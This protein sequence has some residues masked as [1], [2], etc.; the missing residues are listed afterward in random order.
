VSAGLLGVVLLGAC[1]STPQSTPVRTALHDRAITVAS[2]D[3]P[4][5]ELL[6]DIYGLALRD[7]GYAVMFG[8]RLGP[9]ELLDPALAR[10][11]VELVPEYAGTALQF[12]S[13][14]KAQ[15]SADVAATHQAL[16]RTLRGSELV[17]L[18][19]APA[20]DSNAIVVTPRTASEYGLRTISD[21]AKVKALL[22]FGGPPECPNRPLCLQ[23][24]RRTYGL[25]VKS[26]L[27]LDVGGPLTRQAL[28]QSQVDVALMFSTEPAL[29]NAGLIALADDRALQP[30]E[31]IT[32]L[33][34]RD[35]VKRWG[36][37]FVDVV[38]RVSAALT[39]RDLRALNAQVAAGIPTETVAVGWLRK[40]GL[41]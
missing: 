10:G 24:L 25:R 23:G 30:A 21:L 9:R 16:E 18:D 39:T 36:P 22:A 20:Q 19:P 29:F 26:F 34:H 38:N 1:T 32:P 17:A 5:S 12:L 7:N 6:G 37:G 15:A 40:A 27:P 13:L 3:F 8:R 41:R 31:N 35:A 4:E 33:V 11:L 14:G 2:F 28:E